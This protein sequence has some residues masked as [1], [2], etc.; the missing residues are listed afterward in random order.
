[1]MLRQRLALT[2][3]L[4]G[5]PVM[6]AFAWLHGALRERA[7]EEALAQVTMLMMQSGQRERCEADASTWNGGGPR[8]WRE[9]QHE[10]ADASP[11]PGRQ[12]LH[13][14][15]YDAA[16]HAANP[17]APPLQDGVHASLTDKALAPHTVQLADER[18]ATAV[19]V[20]M[21]W[22]TGPCATVVA[23]REMGHAPQPRWMPLAFD[24]M[25]P[26]GVATLSLLLTIGPTVRRIRRLTSEVSRSARE[27]YNG[28]ITL[29]GGDEISGLAQA[30]VD[31]GHEIRT[32]MQEQQ[33]RETALRDFLENT[34]HDVMIPLTVLQ[35]HLSALQAQIAAPGGA[36]VATVTSACNEA[37]YIAALLHN[38]SV[39]AKLEASR[40]QHIREPVDL[41]ALI[42]R[43]AAR[44]APVARQRGIILEYAVPAQVVFVQGDVTL[45]EQAVSNL[46]YNAV[47]Y[48]QA[49]GHVAAILEEHAN[50]RRVRVVDDGPGIAADDMTRLLERHQRG[51]GARARHPSGQGL[52]LNI[53]LRVCAWHG[54]A[55]I[56][57][58]SE[59]GGLQADIEMATTT[60]I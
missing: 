36:D 16:L 44:H 28:A 22:A 5:V 20:H 46:V 2:T 4:M 56:L 50:M 53:A 29:T 17:N 33:L 14:F 34:T 12:R 47:R 49:G 9:A 15:A 58:K 18:C 54:F 26:L 39:V 57:S 6:V 24:L 45:L 11:M 60:V 10:L 55:L 1:M 30:F 21:P 8:A 13:F 42:T 23:C 41:N 52:G 48:N 38:L 51:N 35:G 40:P 27:R 43:V 31:A 59:F 3:V 7:G 25:L 19:L 37:H 32:H